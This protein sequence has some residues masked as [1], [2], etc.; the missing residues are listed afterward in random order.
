M[1][2]YD[3]EGTSSVS[4]IG[5]FF[6]LCSLFGVSIVGGSTILLRDIL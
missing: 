2:W 3:R 5:R 1:Y 4:F 6:L